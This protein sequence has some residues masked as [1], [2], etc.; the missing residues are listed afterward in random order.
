VRAIPSGLKG[1]S[2]V[3][4]GRLLGEKSTFGQSYG[5]LMHAWFEAVEWLDDGPPTDGDLRAIAAAVSARIGELPTRSLPL[6]DFRKFLRG[7]RLAALLS[8]RHYELAAGGKDVKLE[9]LRELPF[10]FR[11]DEELL[12]GTFDRLVLVRQSGRLTAAEVVDFKTDSIT[13]PNQ[14]PELTEFYRPQI[15]AYK[16]ASA[17]ITGLPEDRITA[18]LAFLSADEVVPI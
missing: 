2:R 13:G 12:S 3:H 1:G 9:V 4:L 6:D 5:S 16:R 14:L 8:K 10:A 7:P 18:R 17:R 15:E 11:Q